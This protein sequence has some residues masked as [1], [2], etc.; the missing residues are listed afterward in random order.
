[1]HLRPR[2]SRHKT[3]G[4]YAR[5]AA[6]A[7]ALTLPATFGFAADSAPNPISFRSAVE[8]ALQHSGVMGIAAINQWRAQK[9]YQEARANYIPQITVGSGLGYSYGFPLTLEGSA[10]SVVNFNTSQSF[11]N[12]ALRQF[13]KAAKIDWN[14]T[15]LDTQDKR[16]SVILDTALSYAQLDQLTAKIKTLTEAQQAAEKAQ[17]VSAQRLQE[18]V[19]SKLELTKSQLVT[20]RIRLRIA[21]AQG[22]ADVLREH[23]AHL[24]GV[25]AESIATEPESIP[26]LPEMSQDDD[27]PAQAVENSYTVKLAEQKVASAQARASGEHKAAV[28]PTIDLASQYAYLAKFNNYDLY[29]RNYTA[30]NFSGGM[31]LRI[32]LWNSVQ[33]AKAQQAD[34]DAM[35]ARKQAELT[36]D[37]VR[38]DALK[39][40][41]SLRELSAARDVAKLEWEVSQGDLESVKSR[42]QTGVANTRDEQNAELDTDDK[43]AAYLD[44]EFELSRA[45]LQL[46]RLTGRL[47]GWAKP[48]Q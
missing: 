15:S 39:L 20:A 41:R 21:E 35:L 14:A 2:R 30:N 33:K 29:Y 9:V 17:F 38:E 18:G 10:P 36:K 28:M 43:Q 26:Q 32:P 27:L 7:C 6:L 25:S 16:D 11:Y 1:M 4:R 46:L 24:M 48:G 3:I 8:M 13:V 31:N 12:P 44:A 5:V 34:A 40:Q 23:L 22:Q 19:D 42:V 45:E 37:Q 47:E